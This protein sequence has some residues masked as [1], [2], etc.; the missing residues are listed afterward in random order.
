MKKIHLTVLLIVLL[1]GIGHVEQ[2]TADKYEP[3]GVN[4]WYWDLATINYLKKAQK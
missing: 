4:S 2:A 1:T 3:Y